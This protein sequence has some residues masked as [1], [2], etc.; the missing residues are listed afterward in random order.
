LYADRHLPPA[1]TVYDFWY[2]SPSYTA[3]K[4]G[5]AALVLAAAYA[6]DKIPGPSPLRQ[7]GRTSL[8][9]YWV[10]L[11]IVYGMWLAPGA[12]G[13]LTIE[14]A[15]RGVVLLMLAMLALSLLRTRFGEW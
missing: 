1:Y 13:R 6:F 8:L 15:T 9:V 5:V 12:Q 4:A 2:T 11:E 3:L 14:E 7:L 10:H